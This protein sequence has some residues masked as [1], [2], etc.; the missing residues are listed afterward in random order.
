VGAH[1]TYVLGE[2]GAYPSEFAA[3]IGLTCYVIDLVQTHLSSMGRPMLPNTTRHD[4]LSSGAPSS[5]LADG[6]Q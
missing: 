4:V 5:R 6:V 1:A 3:C 2:T